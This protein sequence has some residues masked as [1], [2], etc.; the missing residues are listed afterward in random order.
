MA[1]IGAFCAALAEISGLVASAQALPDL[2]KQACERVVQHTGSTATY[3]VT[4]DD[5]SDSIPRIEAIAGP[6]SQYIKS[7]DVS[8]DASQPGGNGVFGLVY[9]ARKSMVSQNIPNDARFSPVY[10][11]LAPWNVRSAAGVPLVIGGRCRGALVVATDRS[12]HY[13][14]I[15]V[16]LLERIAETLSMAIDRAETKERSERYQTLYT[17][18]FNVNELIARRPEPQC[19]YEQTVQI[20]ARVS[21]KMRAYVVEVEST[22][23]ALH[24]AACA[25]DGLDEETIEA[26]LNASFSTNPEDPTSQGIGGTSYRAAH[27]VV[28][29]DVQPESETPLRT[30]LRRRTCT[31]SLMGIP[32][33]LDGE[34]KAILV[35]AATEPNYFVGDL[36]PLSERLGESLGLA[37]RAHEQTES[38]RRQALMD[39]LTGLPNRA[40]HRDRLGM[41]IAHAKRYGGQVAVVVIDLDDF[42]MLNSRL[43]HSAGDDAL[44]L[45]A[46]RVAK[47]VRKADTVARLGGDVLAAILPTDNAASHI[48]R[49]LRRMRSAINEPVRLGAERVTLCASLGIAIYPRDGASPEDLIRRADLAMYRAKRSGGD[50][51]RFFEQALEER[52]LQRHRLG[53]RFEAALECGEIVFHFQPNLDLRECQVVGAEALVRWNDPDRGLLPPGEWIDDIEGDSRL[54]SILGRYALASAMRQLRIWHANGKAFSVSVNIGVRHLLSSE[55]INDLRRAL[56]LAPELASYLILELTETALIEDFQAVAKVLTQVRTLGVKIALDDFGTGQ[57]SLTYLLKLPTDRIKIDVS[58]VA[59]MLSCVRAFGIVT[60]AAQGTWLLGMSAVA[61]GVETEEHGVRLKQ[62]GCRYAQGFAIARPMPIEV[63][64]QWLMSW[65]PPASWQKRYERPLPQ[66]YTQLLASLILHRARHKKFIH[67]IRTDDAETA[68]P[69]E[70]KR[71]SYCPFQVLENQ[72]YECVID[73]GLSKI[74]RQLH[75]LEST[76]VNQL[77]KSHSVSENLLKRTHLTLKKYEYGINSVLKSL[78]SRGY[79]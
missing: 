26:M 43:G 54:I 72:S 2:L 28:W 65:R 69:A 29:Q 25:G 42:S 48:D 47:C 74:H 34:H 75:Q 46:A 10:R 55:F 32:I 16:S 63:F 73:I 24:V 5:E 40:L 33:L 18:L 9:R 61:E 8:V 20:I 59:K 1:G 7:I 6:A 15:L 76:C 45:L 39:D 56:R 77:T 17:A 13:N 21:S 71:S 27:T 53:E 58:F 64:D 79:H 38:L 37:L 41:A 3:I 49:T 68:L 66:P 11:T 50:Q 60:A 4:I 22:K 44:K 36:L 31:R 23:E 67:R 14:D 51:W 57:A 62:M 12:N 19:L 52:L 30:R 78:E 35:L 70:V